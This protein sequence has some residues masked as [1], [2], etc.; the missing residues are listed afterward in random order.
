VLG[1]T[2]PA[3][4]EGITVRRKKVPCGAL[5]MALLVSVSFG[6]CGPPED[7][8][9]WRPE[10][11]GQPRSNELDRSR[12]P[13]RSATQATS[14]EERRARAARTLWRVTCASCHGHQGQGDGPS[15]MPGGVTM[16][17]MS[18]AEW[19][20]GITDE[21]M[22]QVIREGRGMMPGFAERLA[23]NAMTQ[24]VVHIRTLGQ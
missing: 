2:M 24:L 13:D 21:A 20:A 15:R 22:M 9:E 11:H 23:P 19:Q 1:A 10:D 3:C 6:A 16:P 5:F 8:R 7:L 18:S 17:D 14:P 4:P 12:V